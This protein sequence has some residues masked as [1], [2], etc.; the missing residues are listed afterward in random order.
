MC[1]ELFFIFLKLQL[2]NAFSHAFLTAIK[3]RIALKKLLIKESYLFDEYILKN[4]KKTL[5][6]FSVEIKLNSL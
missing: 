3:I 4:N 5:I 6:L 1:M 2:I